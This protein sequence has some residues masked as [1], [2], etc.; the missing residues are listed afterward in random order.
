MKKVCVLKRSENT[1]EENRYYLTAIKKF[2]GIPILID[3]NNL[4]KLE[5]CSGI[6]ITGGFQKGILDDYLIEYA[7]NN[8]LPLLG[9]CQGMQSMAM[10]QSDLQLEE[11]SNHHQQE[12]YIHEVILTDSNFKKIV[13]K[14]RIKVNSYHY[15]T[16]RDSYL[17]PIVGR[18]DDGLIEVV[19]NS[20]H[21]FQIGVQWHPERMLTYDLSS[22]KIFQEFMKQQKTK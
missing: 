13:G 1:D 8:K 10:Y 22:N 7:L 16:V 12:G 14:D 17:F 4:D 20:H 21:P 11:V 6:V 5:E 3:E 9:I 18:S 15:Q 2:G 19:E